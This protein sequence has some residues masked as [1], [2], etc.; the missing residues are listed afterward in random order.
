MSLLHTSNDTFREWAREKVVQIHTSIRVYSRRRCAASRQFSP[1]KTMDQSHEYNNIPSSHRYRYDEDAENTSSNKN[2]P[3][4][5][6]TTAAKPESFL[7][8]NIIVGYAFGPKKMETM[9]LIM[10]EAS[11]ALSTFEFAE[12]LSSAMCRRTQQQQQQQQNSND[13][14]E[15]M[16][17]ESS[18]ATSMATSMS[19]NAVTDSMLAGQAAT[20]ESSVDIDKETMPTSTSTAHTHYFSDNDEDARSF[21]S[22]YTRSSFI[23]G[24]SSQHRGSSHNNGVNGIQLT[25][26]PDSSGSI[27]LVRTASGSGGGEGESVTGSSITTTATTLGLLRKPGV[28]STVSLSSSLGKER[29]DSPLKTSSSSR[30]SNG[31]VNATRHHPIR[32]SFVP[33]DLD[34]PLEEQHGGKFD[35]ILHKMTEEILCMSKMLRSQAAGVDNTIRSN[36]DLQ[37]TMTTEEGGNE[38]NSA[39]DMN[40]LFSA[41]SSMTGHQTRASKRLARLS[42]YKKN[43]RPSCVL[44]DSPNNILAVMSRADM[45]TVLS[46]CLVGVRTKGGIPVRTPRFRVVEEVDDCGESSE[47]GNG[48]T[49][50]ATTTTALTDEIDE[51]GFSYPLIAKPLTAAGTKSSHHMGIVLARDGLSQLK[52]PCLLQEYA[53]HG[54]KLYKVYVLG[55]SVWVFSRESLPNL[56]LGENTKQK[57]EMN[58]DD[59]N[60]AAVVCPRV[61]VPEEGEEANRRGEEVCDVS[62]PIRHPRKRPRTESYVE[63]ERPA[64]S[65]YYVEFNSQRPYPKLSDFGFGATSKSAADHM[66]SPND[67]DN[68]MQEDVT[69][70]ERYCMPKNEKKQRLDVGNPLNCEESCIDEGVDQQA[71]LLAQPKLNSENATSTASSDL[72]R[73]VTTEEIEPVTTALREAFGLELF[74]FDVLV[75]YN[76]QNDSA[77]STGNRGSNRDDRKDKEILVVDVNYFPGYKEVPNFPSLL[78]QYLTQKAVESRLRNNFDRS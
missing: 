67:D 5:L 59:Y 19:T 38:I 22:T 43:A 40:D 24:R 61:T 55:E 74:G 69:M 33:V 4:T 17:E 73:C 16:L 35:V 25:F 28:S 76:N 23:S 34:T 50:T 36:G 11:K 6:S 12:S 77:M 3:P 56:P 9:G 44:V 68:V 70:S 42:E 8:D 13:A 15:H 2:E 37:Q 53:N 51:A 64:G 21:S 60:A 39:M 78:A 20:G 62:S 27:H 66:S 31:R 58:G 49:A 54:E 32:V 41:T 71:L 52:T 29:I 45:A 14:V 57:R 48:S 7:L 30:R 10:A 72:A 63:F 18:M 1:R 47:S 75:K 26:L 46:R 65:R